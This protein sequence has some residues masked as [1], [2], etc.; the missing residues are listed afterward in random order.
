MLPLAE[1]IELCGMSH[2]LL[3]RECEWSSRPRGGEGCVGVHG[4][5]GGMLRVGV[6]RQE[7]NRRVGLSGLRLREVFFV[8]DT[9]VAHVFSWV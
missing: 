8:A 7:S 9:L 6:L 4:L 5:V 3:L 2:G 1:L